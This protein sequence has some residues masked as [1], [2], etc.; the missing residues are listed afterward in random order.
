MKEQVFIIV[1]RE[2]GNVINRITRLKSSW[3]FHTV[4]LS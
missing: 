4:L 1:N 2:R 3:S